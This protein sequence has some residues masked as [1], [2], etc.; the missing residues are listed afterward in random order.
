M[1][2]N[3]EFIQ[4]LVINTQYWIILNTARDMYSPVDIGKYRI[5]IIQD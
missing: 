2:F 1:G 3:I 4:K 5:F